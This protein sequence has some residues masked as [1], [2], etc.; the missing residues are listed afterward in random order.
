M[1][2]WQNAN[3]QRFFILEN[4][5]KI[6]KTLKNVKN[7][8]RI[9]NVK[10]VFYIYG[11]VQQ[12]VRCNVLLPHNLIK[13]CM[14]VCVFICVVFSVVHQA[15]YHGIDARHHQQTTASMILTCWVTWPAAVI[16]S[17]LAN[18]DVRVCPKHLPFMQQSDTDSG[19]SR[20]MCRPIDVCV[21]LCLWL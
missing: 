20:E 14:S 2:V 16:D 13:T 8:T 11:Q 10:N 19:N 5:G 18:R 1:K 15:L 21:Y 17:V 12:V 6:K 4:I 9:K 7:V 3:F